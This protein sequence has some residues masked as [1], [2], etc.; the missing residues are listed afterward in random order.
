MEERG[1]RGEKK[2]EKKR[3]K[4]KRSGFF[5]GGEGEQ[6]E[7]RG[8]PAR[9]RASIP[10]NEQ[11]P[12][13][14]KRPAFGSQFLRELQRTCYSRV[15]APRAKLWKP[16]ERRGEGWMDFFSLFTIAD[17]RLCPFPLQLLSVRRAFS[18]DRPSKWTNIA[19]RSS[20]L[21]APSRSLRRPE[22]CSCRVPLPLS[23]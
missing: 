13:T 6:A 17:A 1:V 14:P 7:N 21:R 18:L 10:S 3:E 22:A 5:P 9:K 23:D 2:K 19:R 8:A 4:K 16:R 20:C 12:K 15:A 11:L